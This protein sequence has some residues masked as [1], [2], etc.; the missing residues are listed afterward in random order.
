VGTASQKRN[1]TSWRDQVALVTGRG[2]GIGRATAQLL[3]QRGA[4]V[5][6]NYAVHADAAKGLAE[7]INVGGG[8]AISVKADVADSSAVMS[9][10]DRTKENLDL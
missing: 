10:V 4:A 6:V 3:A 7:E 1:M 5:C 8:R 2:R 9:M